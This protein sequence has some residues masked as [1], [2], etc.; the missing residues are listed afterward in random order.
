MAARK[1]T[2]Q[3]WLRRNNVPFDERMLKVELLHLCKTHKSEP[4]YVV[5]EMLKERG[6]TAIRLPPIMPI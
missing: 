6:H 2:M 5:D 4:R 1:G 3:D